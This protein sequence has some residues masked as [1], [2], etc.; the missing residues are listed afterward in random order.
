MAFK[1]GFSYF[2]LYLVSKIRGKEYWYSRIRE[3]NRKNAE[4][5]KDMMLELQGLFIKAGQLISTLSNVLP[6]EFRAPLEQ[7]QDNVPPHSFETINRAVMK[8]LGKPIDELFTRFDEVPLA[9]ASI[10][11]AHR[12]MLGDKEVVVKVQ[13]PEVDELAH[14]DLTII[15]RIV[16][17]FSK[18]MKI[19][20]MK[21]L[22]EQVE[23]MV[24]DEL[25]YCKEAESMQIIK[26]NVKHEKGIYVPEVYTEYSSKKILTIEYCEGVKISDVDQ[27]LTWNLDL[28]QLTECLVRV[29]CHMILVDGFYH[30]DAHPGNLLVNKEGQIILLDF[31]AVS[32]LSPKMKRG[33]PIL[34]QNMIQQDAGEMVKSLRQLG[35]IANGE[36][37]ARVVRKLIDDIQDF[38]ENELE[39]E[40]LNIQDISEDQLRQALKLVNIRELARIVQIPKEWVLLNR[41]VVLVGGVVYLLDPD[42][43]PVHT[44][45][46]YLE[47][48]LIGG[49]SGMAKMALNIVKRQVTAAATLPVEVQKIIKKANQGKITIDVRNIKEGFSRMQMIGQQI[50]WLIA[51]LAAIYFYVLLDST[52]A[53]PYLTMFFQV[54]GFASFFSFWLTLL[55]T[56]K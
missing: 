32:R 44:L 25:D 9:A 7:L 2:W 8:E 30:A 22:Y 43:N 33:I 56:P 34:I 42:W 40:S 13:H 55:R 1:V 29:F 47:R 31:G 46:P 28:H 18:F 16:K 14:M 4:R 15:K 38:I 11:Q 54:F 52:N 12:A 19:K 26:E 24:E 21:H 17:M 3:K 6:E 27:L 20:G 35:F 48:E 5:I 49:K 41:A 10:G 51:F 39:M 53:Y 50:V 36:A 23:E 45:K 37:T